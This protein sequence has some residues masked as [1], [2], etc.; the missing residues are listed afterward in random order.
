HAGARIRQ[1]HADDVPRPSVPAES[2]RGVGAHAG[3]AGN[4]VDL[5]G[6]EYALH[7]RVSAEGALMRNSIEL[8]PNHAHW[9][10]FLAEVQGGRL[11]GVRP[12]ARDPDPSP[13]LDAI[14]SAVYSPTRIAKPMVRH[15]WLQ[16]RA[17]HAP[18]PPPLT[19]P[20]PA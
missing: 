15:A 1:G 10:A 2:S 9:G 14:P 19:T 16:G 3:R 12:F 7:R 13:M 6:H 20:P 17:G 4:L 11:V 5:A 18:R 8:V